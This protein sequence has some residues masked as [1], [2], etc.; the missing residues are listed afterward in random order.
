MRAFCVTYSLMYQPHA[1]YPTLIGSSDFCQN[2]FSW[3]KGIC[4]EMT[5]LTLYDMRDGWFS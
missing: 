5:I 3:K 2:N 1:V 4:L